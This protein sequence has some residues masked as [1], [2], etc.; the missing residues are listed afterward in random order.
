[1]NPFLARVVGSPERGSV[2]R[3]ASDHN[4][5]ADSRQTLNT[6]S[7]CCGSQ[8]GAPAPASFVRFLIASVFLLNL[9]SLPAQIGP[10][11]SAVFLDF[12]RDEPGLRLEH[13]ARRIRGHYGAALEFSTALQ[14]ATIHLSHRL[15]GIKAMSIG[16]WF[17][18]RRTGE[19]A[20][21]CRGLPEVA[22]GGERLFPRN[23]QWVSFLLGTDQHGFF[24]GTING[25]GW[26]PFPHVNL[27]E[28]FIDEW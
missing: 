12:E 20:F 16:G 13:G 8:S 22:P 24:C 18:P 25:N 5:P 4:S 23:E 21:F 15:D 10:S 17:Y 6:L 11:D 9:G 3:S 14:C 28:A 27:N 19:Q 2:S 26:M 1:M 7:R